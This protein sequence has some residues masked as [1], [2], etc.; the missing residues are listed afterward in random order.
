MKLK[1]LTYPNP[2]LAKK[3]VPVDLTNGVPEHISALA[4]S[5]LE[6]MYASNGIGLA[7]PQVGIS[8]RMIVLDLDQD[9]KKSNP[10]V[11]INPEIIKQNGKQPSKEGCLS[12]PF[13]FETVERSATILFKAFTL[14]GEQVEFEATGDYANCLQHELGHLD[15]ILFIDLLSRLKRNLLLKA[16][17]KPAIGAQKMIDDIAAKER[18]ISIM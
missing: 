6:T 18:S 14:N 3:A 15:G 7:A 10:Q 5:M 16:M 13:A 4:E 12:V 11:F 2:I 1:V 8:I 9:Q 17:K